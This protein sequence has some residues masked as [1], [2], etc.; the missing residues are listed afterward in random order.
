MLTKKDK[1]WLKEIIK[2]TVKEALTVEWTVEKV[3]DEKTG[4][5]LTVPER[6]TEE[7]FI[8]SVF[9]QLLPFYEQSIRGM[10]EDITK[11]NN[12]IN[13]MQ[14]KINVVGNI[15][16]QTESSL[17]C[18]AAMSDHIKQ[19]DFD[20]TKLIEGEVINDGESDN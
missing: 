19:L 7:V 13:E 4:M 1:Q 2:E 20:D 12:K 8:P 10:H 18:I 14:D 9:V 15:M 5:P 6:K 16:I 3:R 17:K 11:N